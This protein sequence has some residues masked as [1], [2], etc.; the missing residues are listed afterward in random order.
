MKEVSPTGNLRRFFPLTERLLSVV[1]NFFLLFIVIIH[2][3]TCYQQLLRCTYT[4]N[5]QI[6]WQGV[7][8]LSFFVSKKTSCDFFY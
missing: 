5:V 3:S 7:D 1:K 2:F 8:E 4:K 6:A